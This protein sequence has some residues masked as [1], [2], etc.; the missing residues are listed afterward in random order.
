M[1]EK[2]G[3]IRYNNNDKEKKNELKNCINNDKLWS[4]VSDEGIEEK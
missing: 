3:N 1:G 4:V 2:M